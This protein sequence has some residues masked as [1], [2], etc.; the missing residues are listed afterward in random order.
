MSGTR[1]QP[2]LKYVASREIPWPRRYSPKNEVPHVLGIIPNPTEAGKSL[3]GQPHLSQGSVSLSCPTPILVFPSFRR[4][5]YD[6]HHYKSTYKRDIYG[7][8]KCKHYFGRSVY[9]E[10]SKTRCTCVFR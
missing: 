4:L 6:L 5:I 10:I 7:I 2:K 1:H 9:L 8:F 3:G